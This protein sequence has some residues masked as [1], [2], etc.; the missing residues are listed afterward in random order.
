[1]K[2]MISTIAALLVGSLLFGGSASAATCTITGST[3]SGSNNQCTVNTQNNTNISNTNVVDITNH[4][5]QSAQSGNTSVN[6]NTT[7][8]N[9]TSGNATNISRA[10]INVILGGGSANGCGSSTS[11]PNNPGGH[12]D[13][14]STSKQLA[15]QV[16]APTGGVKAGVNGLSY[17][18]LAASLLSIATGMRRLHLQAREQVA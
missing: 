13:G 3:G 14:T 11:T 12:V 6:G 9:A 2:V 17:V 4:N 15:A 8:G 1:M 18:I 7:G 5:P 16:D 10:C